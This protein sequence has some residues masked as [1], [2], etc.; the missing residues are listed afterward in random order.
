MATCWPLP[1]YRPAISAR[2]S[3]VQ[4]IVS[5]TDKPTTGDD[6]AGRTSGPSSL[7]SREPCLARIAP[8]API[9]HFRSLG[10]SVVLW[11]PCCVRDKRPGWLG[12]G[13]ALR[14]RGSI[15]T[16]GEQ[17]GDGRRRPNAWSDLRQVVSLDRRSHLAQT[18][19]THAPALV[20]VLRVRESAQ[21]GSLAETAEDLLRE[22]RNLLV[23][24]AEHYRPEYEAAIAARRKR[25]VVTVADMVSSPK[26]N[27]AWRLADGSRTQ[28]QISQQSTLDEGSTSKLFKALREIGA[29]V[30]TPNPT[31]TLEIG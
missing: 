7:P 11:A 9:G 13:A 8:D 26:R 30:D 18:P 31:R 27:A 2:R 20:V 23:P 28:R 15:L 19:R 21:E 25:L 10:R 22:I 1:R 12:E 24:I 5:P 6:H 29:I 14:A 17:A 4:R 16:T 3:Q